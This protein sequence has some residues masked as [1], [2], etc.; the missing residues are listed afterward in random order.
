MEVRKKTQSE[1]A[2]TDSLKEKKINN[3]GLKIVED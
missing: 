1:H 3:L 2:S